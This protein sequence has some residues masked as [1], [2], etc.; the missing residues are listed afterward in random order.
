MPHGTEYDD[1]AENNCLVIEESRT[2]SGMKAKRAID[3]IL[4]QSK[5]RNRITSELV[6]VVKN[7]SCAPSSNL[8]R[9]KPRYLPLRLFPK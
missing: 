9:I 6:E 3:D 8:F 2:E 4:H 5:A 1:G 7:L